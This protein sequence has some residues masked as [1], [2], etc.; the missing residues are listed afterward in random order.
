VQ[1]ADRVLSVSWL[2]LPVGAAVTAAVC[3]FALW[4]SPNADEAYRQA[5]VLHGA[6]RL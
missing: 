6:A 4:S 3:G 2:V 5:V 1:L